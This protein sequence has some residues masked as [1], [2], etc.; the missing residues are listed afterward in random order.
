M[1][2]STRSLEQ[3][4]R[5][6]I[7][8]RIFIE[9]IPTKLSRDLGLPVGVGLVLVA[10]EVGE[11][12]VATNVFVVGAAALQLSAAARRRRRR[13]RRLHQRL[14]TSERGGRLRGFQGLVSGSN[15]GF[16]F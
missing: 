3:A 13:R 4:F 5:R 6:L 2:D 7:L 10:G 14:L 15:L 1:V 11:G 16:F 12:S 8:W 9:C